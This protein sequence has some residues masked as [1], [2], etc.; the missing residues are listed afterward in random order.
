MIKIAKPYQYLYE[1]IDAILGERRFP[2]DEINLVGGRKSA[3][4]VSVQIMIALLVALLKKTNKKIGV[5]FFRYQTKDASELY[6]EIIDTLNIC[7][8]PYQENKTRLMIKVGINTIRVIGLNSQNKTNKAKKSGLARVGGTR[9][10]IRIF[11]EAFEFPQKDVLALKEAVR[12]LEDDVNML[13]IHICNPWAKSSWFV[14][15]CATYQNWDIPTLRASGSQFGLYSIKL[16]EGFVKKVVFHYTNWRAAINDDGASLLGQSDI[17]SILDTWNFDKK[18]ALT[19]DLGIPG[20]EDN[21]IYTHLINN[22]GDVVYQEHE[23]LVG[24]LDWGWGTNDYSSKT[25][26]LF[27]GASI[28]SGIDVY[29]EYVSDNRQYSKNPEQVVEEIVFFY[30]EQMEQYCRRIGVDTPFPLK[31]RVDYMNVGIILSL[32]TKARELRVGHWLS[33]VKCSK[34]FKT[35]DRIDLTLGAMGKQLLRINFRGVN[36]LKANME[37]AY[38][39]DIETR[40]R[41]KKNDDALN[42]FEYGIE[43]FIFKL[44]KYNYENINLSRLFLNT[45]SYS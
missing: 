27:M 39:E 29:G 8:V 22:I 45:R 3:K 5:F 23:Y 38:Y 16:Q 9:Y 30:K 44:A 36:E 19:T 26:A 12:G 42:A 17:S 10:I 2:I 33:F 21:A 41:V 18:R 40:K 28:E 37:S 34:E 15:Y 11:E 31:V 32:N 20:Y 35:E 7:D 6:D 13:D 24:G 43:P 14:S 4:S 1:I 25:V